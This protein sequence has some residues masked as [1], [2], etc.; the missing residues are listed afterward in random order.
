M[1]TIGGGLV[2][3]NHIE[4]KWKY[5]KQKILKLYE[6]KDSQKFIQLIEQQDIDPFTLDELKIRLGLSEIR[7]NKLVENEN[8][9]SW[10]EHKNSKWVLTLKQ[11]LLLMNKIQTH[12]IDFHKKNPLSVGMQKEEMIRV[13]AE[14][15]ESLVEKILK[16]HQRYLKTFKK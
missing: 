5:V 2:L 14:D 10:L 3:D 16:I 13:I 11:R 4:G 6:Q 15:I 1:I 7:I 12:L 9:L 8:N